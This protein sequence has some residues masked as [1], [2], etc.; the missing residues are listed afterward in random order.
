MSKKI[1]GGVYP[2]MITPYTADNKIDFNGVEQILQWYTERGVDG[3]FAIC[4]SS[5]IFFLSFEERLALLKFIMEHKPQG[6]NIV[7]SG[8]TADDLDTQIEEAKHFIDCGIDAYVFISNRF[9]KADESDDV[10]MEN[11]MKAC[12]ALPGIDFG[13]YECPYPYK[14]LLT[15]EMLKEMVKTNRFRF[16]KDTCCNLDQ[17]Q[18]KVDAV[19]GSDLMI[20]NANA[21]TFLESMKMGCSGYSGVMANFHPELY[22]EL[23]ANIDKDPAKAQKLQDIVGFFSVAECQTYPINAKYYMTL[24]GLDINITSRARN[25]ADFPKNRALEIDQM[26]ALTQYIKSTL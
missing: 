21:A 9:A 2:T 17:L 5:E 25:I 24:D 6:V 18:A 8:H 13:I 22:S 11:M 1:N 16:I 19:K 7:A 20:F 26:H 12:D 23:I 14:R 4:Q 3:I 10:F 15:P